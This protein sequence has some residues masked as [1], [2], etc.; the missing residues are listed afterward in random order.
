[1]RSSNNQTNRRSNERG[2][3][4][5]GVTMVESMVAILLVAIA[6]IGMIKLQINS[7]RA[8]SESRYDLVA[9]G[10]AQEIMEQISYLGFT[11]ARWNNAANNVVL[12][13]WIQGLPVALPAGTGSVSCA[14][15][16]CSVSVSW[17]PPGSDDSN[18]LSYTVR[19]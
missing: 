14:S 15:N 4:Q 13:A 19:N 2:S 6:M 18:T 5:R 3:K 12:N 10:R 7:L 1:M 9:S 11:D 16:V 8:S 17:K